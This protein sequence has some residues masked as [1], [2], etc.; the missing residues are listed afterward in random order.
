MSIVFISS[1]CTEKSPFLKASQAA[2]QANT[3]ELQDLI[4]KYPN[5]I[6]EESGFD[7]KTLLYSALINIPSYD[8]AKLLLDEGSDPNHVDVTG[9]TPLSTI[10]K[11]SNDQKCLDLLL[12]YGAKPSKFKSITPS[13]LKPIKMQNKSQ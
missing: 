6:K 9:E 2:T 12:S 4:T 10:K 8:C 13:K 11:Y 3:A 7:G 5:L 1:A